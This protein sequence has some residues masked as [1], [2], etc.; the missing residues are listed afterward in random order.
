MDNEDI[1][2][3]ILTGLDYEA[4]KLIIDD[5]NARDTVISFEE[6]H[7]IYSQKK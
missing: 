1:V 7:E 2:D 5:V 3:Q 6:L 4:Y